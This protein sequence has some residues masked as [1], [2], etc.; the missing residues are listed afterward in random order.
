[1]LSLDR[2]AYH[3]TIVSPA[4]TEPYHEPTLTLAR[5]QTLWPSK[6]TEA[7]NNIMP[8]M[9]NLVVEANI[10]NQSAGP[11]ATAWDTALRKVREKARSGSLQ[12]LNAT[13]NCA[14]VNPRSRTSGKKKWWETSL[15]C[16]PL[17]WARQ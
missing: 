3:P 16:C 17:M 9:R 2:S 5:M 6:T 13:T 8:E 15:L 11:V 12:P 4:T 7:L 10:K 1:M 14:P